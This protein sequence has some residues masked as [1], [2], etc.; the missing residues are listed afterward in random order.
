VTRDPEVRVVHLADYGGPYAGSFVP[1]LRAACRRVAREAWHPEI[2]L[3][4]VARDRPW[5]S[6]LHEEGTRVRFAPASGSNRSSLREL[7]AESAAP[8]VLHTHFT[9]FDLPAA[10]AARGRT[11]TPVFWH[12]H[13]HVRSTPRVLASNA[14]KYG[15]AGRIVAGILC[16][17]PDVAAAT[18]RRLAPGD[19]VA[20]FPNA[21]DTSRFVPASRPERA[22][23]RARLGLPADAA[24][25]LH[26]GWD[27]LRK[28]G[29]LFLRAASLL[30]REGRR[31]AVLTVGAGD[32]A[33]ALATE[34]GLG[35][36]LVVQPPT[37][38]LPALYASADVFVSSSRA[39]GMPFAVTEALCS[40]VPVVATNLPGHVVQCAGLAAA[41][42]TTAEPAHLAEAIRSLLDRDS[43]TAAAD[44]RDARES[45]VGRFDLEAWADRLFHLYERAFDGRTGRA[46]LR[47]DELER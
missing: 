30:Q 33:R 5:L 27:W 6:E 7:L 35:G 15:I 39:E 4:D 14:L 20:F 21:I 24:V 26:F 32:D 43:Q 40:G 31:L 38:E 34:L 47:F 18:R 46:L 12:L 9:S 16:V 17:A 45:I 10:L 13:H 25:L 41:R 2:V 3:A 23:A 29:D 19:R 28:G 1:M 44:A 36:S 42:L 22:A 11:R 37:D 8:T